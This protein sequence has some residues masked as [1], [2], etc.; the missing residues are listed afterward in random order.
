MQ[1]ALSGKKALEF[2]RTISKLREDLDAAETQN[3]ALKLEALE[4][5]KSKRIENE[6]SMRELKVKLQKESE[7]SNEELRLQLK[8]L[9]EKLNVSET[10]GGKMEEKLKESTSVTKLIAERNAARQKAVSMKSEL[11]HLLAENQADNKVKEQR[12]VS[13][14]QAASENGVKSSFDIWRRRKKKNDHKFHLRGLPHPLTSSSGPPR[15]G[16]LDTL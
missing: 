11:G 7:R 1:Y 8:A 14:M 9:E 5:E 12:K 2:E 16:S 3:R 15:V 10:S 6:E 4:L 13:E